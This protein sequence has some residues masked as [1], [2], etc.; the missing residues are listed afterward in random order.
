[1]VIVLST[2]LILFSFS[3]WWY[4][5]AWHVFRLG[6]DLR[7]SF[8]HPV[9]S[10]EYVRM[11]SESIEQSGRDIDA[12]AEDLYKEN[13]KFSS[14]IESIPDPL[15]AIGHKG[16]ILFYNLEF[17]K[18]FCPSPFRLLNYGK[19]L[20]DV[21][22]HPQVQ[23]LVEDLLK[24]RQTR[25]IHQLKFMRGEHYLGHFDVIHSDIKQSLQSRSGVVLVFH[26]VRARKLA[27]KMRE[28][29]VANV[30]HE[31]RTPLTALNGFLEILKKD[32]SESQL[33][34]QS[35][36]AMER[37]SQN[38]RRLNALFN[39]ILQL[40]VIESDADVPLEEFSVEELTSTVLEDLQRHY[41]D[42]KHQI[43]IAISPESEVI[44]ANI[45]WIE[46]VLTN[47]IENAYK[48]IPT[49]GKIEIKW[50]AQNQRFFC[51][52]HDN[53]PGI[54]ERY[55][56]RI[57]ERFFRIDRARSQEIPGTGLGL[58]IVKHIMMKHNGEISVSS[59]PETG[60]T[61]TFNI[62]MSLRALSR[63]T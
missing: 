22:Y 8:T 57:F 52:V 32:L 43:T 62:P 61:F 34:A 44:T 51:S 60:T 41:P 30:S 39:D 31:V 6:R 13:I 5:Y 26:D 47:L 9:W 23:D 25:E 56:S 15:V 58:A 38:S 20:R 28:D 16:E 42:K 12:Y 59:T 35:L 19:L 50:W 27:D 37:I 46:Q 17:G 45:K 3:W 1:M 54:P 11:I 24:G 49:P 33:S 18:R 36:H 55:Q 4:P 21:F 10:T 7:P 2:G 63:P 14:L 53:G 29:F 40:S 48:Y